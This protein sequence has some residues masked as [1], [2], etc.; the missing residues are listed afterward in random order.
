MWL[1]VDAEEAKIQLDQRRATIDRN[2]LSLASVSSS[3]PKLPLP[4]GANKLLYEELGS[5]LTVLVIAYTSLCDV[6]TASFRKFR[7]L[8]RCSGLIA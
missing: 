6:P 8:H 3:C 5:Y 4:Q 1:Q 2:V 7:L